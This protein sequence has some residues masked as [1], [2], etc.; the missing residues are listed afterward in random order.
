M[1]NF[2]TQHIATL[3]GATCCVRLATLLR[4]VATCCNMLGVCNIYGCCMMLWSFGQ[5]RP[6]MLRLGMRQVATR[7]NTVAKSVQHVAPRDRSLGCAQQCCELLRSNAAIVWPE[8]ANAVPT[9]LGY[10]AIVWPGPKLNY[11]RI[12]R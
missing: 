6:T 5:V 8:I 1:S 12:R 11:E 4:R 9:M 2:S 3:L 10:V 7:C